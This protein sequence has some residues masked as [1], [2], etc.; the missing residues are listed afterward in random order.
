MD[1]EPG[2]GIDD[3]LRHHIDRQHRSAG[4]RRFSLRCGFRLHTEVEHVVHRAPR[5]VGQQ[6]RPGREPA[7]LEETGHDEPAFRDE[8]AALF[9]E[10]GVRDVAVVLQPGV[11]RVVNLDD[12]HGPMLS[13]RAENAARTV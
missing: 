12:W 5:R 9:D 10:F 13:R 1:V 7:V 6:H 11:G 8:D 3:P 4:D 2:N